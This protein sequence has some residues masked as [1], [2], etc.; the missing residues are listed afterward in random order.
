[1]SKRNLKIYLKELTKVQLEEQI[2][3]LYIRFK[4]VKTY[5]NFVFKP[6]EEKLLDEA[7][8][9]ISKEYF[10]L[11]NRKPKARRSVAQKIIKHF[12]QLGVDPYVVVEIMLF[13]IE[14]AQKFSKIKTVRQDA[15]YKSILKSFIEVVNYTFER[16]MLPDFKLRMIDICRESKDQEWINHSAFESLLIKFNINN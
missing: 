2:L 3:D 10:P 9:K 7:K 12:I 8:F 11:N 16:T 5:Y 1:V 13:N 14:I 6:N 15:F 4:P